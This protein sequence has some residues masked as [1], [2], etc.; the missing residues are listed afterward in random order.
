MTHVSSNFQRR[1]HFAVDCHLSQ[2]GSDAADEAPCGPLPD[3][4]QRQPLGLHRVLP[5]LMDR[6]NGTYDEYDYETIMAA[7]IRPL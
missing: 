2:R 4:P 6:G 3:F 1:H 5:C 7:N